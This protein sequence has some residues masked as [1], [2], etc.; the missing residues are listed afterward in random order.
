MAPPNAQRAPD[1]SETKF[2]AVLQGL[3]S[4]MRADFQT[5]VED[6]RKEV[7]DI[8]VRMGALEE[9]TDKLCLANNKVVDKIHKMEV[10]HKRLVDKC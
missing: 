2:A 7:H 10:D 5:A 6:I 3:R 8:G 4:S 1:F 9:C